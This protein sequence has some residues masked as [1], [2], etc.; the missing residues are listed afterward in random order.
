MDYRNA[1]KYFTR[2]LR[3][4]NEPRTLAELHFFKGRAYEELGET[5]HAVAQ[6]S[7]V[8]NNEHSGAWGTQADR[9]MVML[10]RFYEQKRSVGK[11]A[12]MRLD[13]YRDTTFMKNID[14]YAEM[15]KPSSLQKK[16]QRD[17]KNT[18]DVSDDSVLAMIDRIGQL[19]L[20]GE[21]KDRAQRKE[22]E[23]MRRE[24]AQSGSVSAQDMKKLQHM[25]M[26][27]QHPYRTPSAIKEVIKSNSGQLRYL[28]K[29]QLRQGERFSGQLFLRMKIGP[30]GRVMHTSVIKSTLHNQDFVDMVQQRV[31]T[32]DFKTVPDSLG[33]LTINYPFEFSMEE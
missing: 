6:Y 23:Q 18:E 26:L 21:K 12:H 30:Q 24:L 28:F 29:K 14:R 7:K 33:T 13:A 15:L 5:K 8:V 1:I 17:T 22:L 11:E 4:T 27:K 9:R 3:N 19:D 25:Q 31:K 10:G 16:L 2:A 20:T 32:W